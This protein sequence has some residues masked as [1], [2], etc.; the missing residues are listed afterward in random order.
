MSRKLE[1]PNDHG[2]TTDHGDE[3][4]AMRQQAAMTQ[5]DDIT[6]ALE[7]A[8][9]NCAAALLEVHDATGIVLDTWSGPRELVELALELI[10]A[11]DQFLDSHA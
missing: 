7:V 6:S 1:V 8:M 10:G 11:D 9:L 3:I 4:L 2:G 5:G